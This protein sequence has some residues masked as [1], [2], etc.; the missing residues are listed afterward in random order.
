MPRFPIAFSLLLLSACDNGLP[1]RGG[2]CLATDCELRY[3]TKPIQ[4]NELEAAIGTILG[5]D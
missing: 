5:N 2:P 4:V 3:L 1:A